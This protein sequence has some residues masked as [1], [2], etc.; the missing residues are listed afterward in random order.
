[1]QESSYDRPTPRPDENLDGQ[2]DQLVTEYVERLITGEQLDPQEII[3]AHPR[4]A[5]ELLRQLGAFVDLGST[6]ETTVP[7]GTLGDYTLRRQIGRGGMG[8]VYEAWENSMDRRVALKVLPAGI[9]ADTKACTRFMREAQTAGK[10]N[11]PNVVGVY[12]TGVKEGTPWYSMELV[13]GETLAQIL[14]K[15]KEAGPDIETPFGKKHEQQFYLNLARA[16]ADVAD[17]LQHAHSKG[18]VH[19]DM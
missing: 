18:V 16:L 5:A 1:M 9:A 6:T 15:T 19:R 3:A 7:L 2:V 4:L 13:E 10:L 12:S 17:G 14:A 8:V 11:H